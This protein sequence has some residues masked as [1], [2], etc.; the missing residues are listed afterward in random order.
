MIKMKLSQKTLS[1]F[2]K[3]LHSNIKNKIIITY[4]KN[5]AIERSKK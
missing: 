4:S 1:S 2:D 5:V 3:N